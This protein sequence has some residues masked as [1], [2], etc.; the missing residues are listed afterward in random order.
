[1]TRDRLLA[2]DLGTTGVRA[3]VVAADGP[4][5]ARAYQPLSASY[6]QPGWL[7][8][9]PLEMWSSSVE[10]MRAALAE[11]GCRAADITALGVVTQRATV[12]AWD[13]QTGEPLAPAIGWQDQR[14]TERVAGFRAAG[15]PLT[16]LA[17]ATKFEWWLE[18][19]EQV[20]RAAEQG[21]LCLGT[22]DS[23]LTA[24]LTGAGL[25][26]TDPGHASCT[27]LY[28]GAGGVWAQPL[29][30]LFSVPVEALPQ[31]VPTSAVVG[32]TPAD[33][34]GASIPVAARAGD[35]QASAF[36]QGVH[37]P[38]QSKLTLGTSAMLDVHTGLVAIEPPS[39][40]F[41]LTLW[42]LGDAPPEFCVEG[43]VITA[44]SAVDWAVE[45]GLARD[46]GHV[47][48]LAQS[49]ESS[50]D[51]Y[52]VPALQ[53]LGTPY[54]DDDARGLFVGLTRGS[55]R[56][57][58][59]RAILEGVAHRVADLSD[60]L[61]S[62]DGPLRCDG[63]L[64]QSNFLV[65]R[66]ADLTGRS[67]HRAAETEATALGAAWLAGLAIDVF[68]S[69]AAV[70]ARAAAPTPFEPAIAAA[71]R[72]RLRTRWRAAVDRTRSNSHLD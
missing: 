16:T 34:L 1:V 54:A 12:V 22:P 57:E 25:H 11:A 31:V 55:G 58:L 40:A 29:C 38:G 46:P 33:L 64:A 50:G 42:Q 30:D 66:I 72:N 45:L 71:K 2:L 7:E 5:L 35:Q 60:A 28:D 4:V 20:K 48:E 8:Q 24:K 26:V 37:E 43:S 67:V 36:A 13:K 63:G 69:L 53:G 41:P 51:V 39:G 44:G 6:P 52:F 23:W 56:P 27:A 3:L 15:I 59:C 62:G 18:H 68:E 70:A 9:D 49:V 10:V 19:D 47:S 21:R 61:V 17:S 14:T 65:Q 32:E